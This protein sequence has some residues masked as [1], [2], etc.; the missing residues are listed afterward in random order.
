MK[1]NI[2]SP[3]F[4]VVLPVYNVE[5]YLERCID[6]ILAQDYEDYEIILVDDGAKD[7]SSVMCDEWVR[8]DHRIRTIHK[9]NAG[10]GMAR[11]TGLEAACGKYIFFIDSDDYILPGLFRAIYNK[12]QDAEYDAVFYGF[13]RVDAKGKVL[14]ELTPS[15]SQMVYTNHDEIMNMLLPDFIARDPK[16][17]VSRN[18]RIS[19]WNCCLNREL[20]CSC[21]LKF[22]SEREFISEDI[23]FYIE[24]F[25]RL[26]SVAFLSKIYYCYCQNVGSLTFS[27]KP[28]RYDRLKYFYQKVTE[29]ADTLGYDGAVQ[30]RLKESFIAS[31]M[32]CLKMEAANIT[33]AGLKSTY[34]KIKTICQD[35]YLKDAVRVYPLEFYSYTWKIFADCVIHNRIA[36]LLVLLLCQYRLKGI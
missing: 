1:N 17:G 8:K 15:P 33:K 4:S 19:A 12:I 31:V 14:L 20:L 5:Q 29:L 21:G 24:L 2:K 36:I 13:Q 3:F 30:F 32:G 9:E 16:T 26:K 25:Q 22:V 23:Y 34:R 35:D 10:L 27:Y 7:K 11:N 6:S 28:E 18:I